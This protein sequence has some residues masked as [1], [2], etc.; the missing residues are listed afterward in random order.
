MLHNTTILRASFVPFFE[1]YLVAGIDHVKNA[2]TK[3][4]TRRKKHP[5][6]N[7]LEGM[8]FPSGAFA[9][10]ARPKMLQKDQRAAI[11]R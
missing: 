4:N 9:D 7:S 10:D 2:A 3:L 8:S 6:L 5:L 1:P 11:I